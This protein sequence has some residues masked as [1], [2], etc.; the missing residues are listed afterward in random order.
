[1]VQNKGIQLLTNPNQ[2]KNTDSFYQN[3]RYSNAVSYKPDKNLRQSKKLAKNNHSNDIQCWQINLHRCKVATYNMHEVTKHSSSG[4]LLIQEP[5]TYKNKISGKLKGWNLFY[6]YQKDKRPRACIYCTPN[7]QC[8]FLPKYSNEDTVAVRVY[9]VSQNGD[10]FIFVSTYMANEEPAPPYVLRELLVF[11]EMEKIPT[12][13]GTD[14][15]AHH[16][17]WGSSNVNMRGEELLEYCISANLNFCNVGNKPTFRTKNRKEVLDLTL[18]NRNAWNHVNNWYVSNQCSF[19][20][21]MYIRF[22]VKSSIRKN[23][24]MVR[25]IRRTH[26]EKY[27][28]EIDLQINRLDNLLTISCLQDI[29]TLAEKLQ[30]VIINSYHVAC[31]LKKATRKK[32]NTWWNSELKS[33]QKKVRRAFRRATKTDSSKDWE[34]KKKA[35]SIFKKAIRKAKR[36]SWHKYTESMN[37]YA[38]TARLVKTIHRNES[39]Q[40]NSIIKADGEYSNSATDTLNCLLD[41]LSPGSQETVHYNVNLEKKLNRSKDVAVIADICSYERMRDAIN[42]FQPFKTP[43]PDG[44]YP[45]LLQ[46]GFELIKKYYHFLFQACLQH[47]YVPRAWKEGHGIFIPKPGKDN[48]FLVTSYRMITLT[49]FQL[50][51]MERLILYHLNDNDNLKSKLVHTQYG[52]RVGVSTETALHEFVRRI[53]SNFKKKKLALGIFLDIVGAFDNITFNNITA[54]L[55]MLGVPSF[56]TEWINDMLRHRKIEVKLQNVKIKREVMKGNPQ[57]GLLSPFLWNCLLNSLLEEYIKRGIYV[58]AYADDLAILVSGHEMTWVRGMAQKAINIAVKWATK[59]ELLF[60]SKKTEVVLFTHK[61]KINFVPLSLNGQKVSL[62][63]EARLL[64]ITLDSKLSWKS[65]IKRIT[66]KATTSLVQCRQIVGNSW[67]LKP[68]IMK[69]VY[70]AM[71]RPILTYAC[72]TWVTGINKL[73]LRKKLS[74]VQRLA[75]L[76]ISSAFPSTPTAALEMLLNIAPINE[77]IKAEAVK[78]SY[79]IDRAGL[80]QAR[81]NDSQ[82][83]LKSHVGVC[84]SIR[85]LLPLLDMPADLITK[86]MVFEREFECQIVKQNNEDENEKILIKNPIECYTDGSKINGRAGAGYYIKYPNAGGTKTK[87]FYLGRYSTVFQAEVFAISQMA[88]ELFE[89]NLQNQNIAVFVDSQAA[90]NAISSSTIKSKT[91]LQCIKNLNK[92]GLANNILVAWTPSHAGFHGNEIADTL[93]KSGSLSKIQGPEP[94]VQVPYVSCKNEIKEW[95]IKQWKQ[96]WFQRKDCLRTKEHVGWATAQ[97]CKRILNLNR[98][99]L[100]Q[101][102]Q[103]LTG[104]CN[105]QRHKKTTNKS[106]CSI[107]PKCNLEEETP[108]HFVGRCSKYQDVRNKYLGSVETTIK[109]V[110]EKLNI[111]KLAQYLKHAGRLVEYDQ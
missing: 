29:E 93:A 31:P 25:N 58:Q 75:C 89:E 62:S 50:K 74:K 63:K 85:K 71:I 24:K 57:G 49:S 22:T 41:A 4:I 45:V 5:W 30:S 37:S 44:I 96:S 20:D 84:N 11:S 8:S 104:H 73:Y 80:W 40:I 99:Q 102:M 23:T 60:S 28:E 48:Y 10:S 26:W 92:L 67:G 14:A 1:M 87:C 111:N 21:H 17:I 98:Y 81:I 88:L 70:I 42:K 18:V 86:T 109:K 108:D 2:C 43:G 35:Q 51:W 53:E 52:F 55:Q 34:E 32:G 38:P 91:V 13:I 54:A 36:I 77:F 59:Q 68:V 106:T 76:M 27:T 33:L 19:S 94:F 107:C 103:I 65:H 47:S 90:I 72:V 100:N 82:K 66:S 79:R 7:L 9:N 97:L 56:I 46:K 16:T 61:R 39:I 6:Y 95:S 3:L 101:V 12:I 64:G 83:S 110:V 105:L 78:G 69:W 15:N